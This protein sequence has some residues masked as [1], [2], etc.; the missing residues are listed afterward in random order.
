MTDAK[1]PVLIPEFD[2]VYAWTSRDSGIIER[3]TTCLS[4]ERQNVFVEMK[5]MENHIL[6]LTNRER[7]IGVLVW[8][9]CDREGRRRFVAVKRE[10]TMLVANMKQYAM[11]RAR[12]EEAY[13]E[14]RDVIKYRVFRWI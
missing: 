12:Q 3:M 1:Y 14:L 11:M 6:S 2:A 7:I 8:S 9:A 5:E 13:R 4:R 10:K